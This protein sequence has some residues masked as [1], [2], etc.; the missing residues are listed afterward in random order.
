MGKL[1]KWLRRLF[2]DPP[3]HQPY[4]PRESAVPKVPPERS[5][6]EE[7]QP[8][9]ADS[10]LIRKV[11]PRML[12]QERGKNLQATDSAGGRTR[13]VY[14]GVDFGTALTK[15]AVRIADFVFFIPWNEL[16]GD[17]GYLLPGRLST[18][19]NGAS[20]P[21]IGQIHALKEPFLPG[22]VAAEDDHVRA[23]EFLSA[24]MRFA[25]AWLFDN[26]PNLVYAYSLGVERTNRLSNEPVRSRRF[27]GSV[28]ETG[29]SSLGCQS[30][31]QPCDWRECAA[32]FEGRSRRYRCRS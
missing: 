24:V 7:T 10:E 1:S 3:P 5:R 25:R 22:N 19:K 9:S 12:W 27:Q 11:G 15:V 30:D 2:G 31:R 23:V 4:Q 29:C 18:T 20:V 14:L 21:G 28:S 6:P 17:G 16:T 32:H 8:R 26:H 13:A